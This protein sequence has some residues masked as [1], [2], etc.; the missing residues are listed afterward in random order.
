MNS[1]RIIS[2]TLALAAGSLLMSGCG[3]PSAAAPSGP[4][5]FPVKI[6][7]ARAQL[8]PDST[9]YLATLKSRNA[10]ELRPQV[11]GDITAIFVRA[12][13]QVQA[14]TPVLQID[15][16]KQEAAVSNQVA[17]HKSKLA[18][19][20]MNLVDLERK[21]KLYAAGVIAKADLDVSQT[22]YDTS[23]ADAE[24]LDAAIREQREQLRYYTVKAA[25]AGVIGDIPVRVGDHV[26]SATTLT[27][28]DRGGPLEAYINVP[29]EKSAQVKPGTQVD[30]VD[31]TGQTLLRTQV[32][33]VS[34]HMDTATQTLLIKAPMSNLN[35][36]FLNEQQVHA[37]VIWSEHQAPLIP[38]TAV[39]RLSGKVFAFVVDSQGQQTVARQ[40]IITVGDLIGNDYVVLDGIQPGDRIIVSGVQILADGMP[41]V[42]QS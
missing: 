4:Q 31:E 26:T 10:A 9:D 7:I 40:R 17:A 21:K 35:H 23:K 15:S 28:L 38:V 20:A 5:G 42:P 41:V 25:T 33:F 13:A 32:S 19:V 12:G 2:G 37:R 14:G 11:E 30:I 34:P 18:T 29:A 3:K 27:T 36:K 22:A 1:R 39:S 8:V 6:Q 16:R 24:A